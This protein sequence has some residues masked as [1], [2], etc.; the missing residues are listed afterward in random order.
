MVTRFRPRAGHSLVK[1]RSVKRAGLNGCFRPLAGHS[2]VNNG[3]HIHLRA[4]AVFVPLRG[5]A[6]SRTRWA[7]GTDRHRFRPLA[8]HSLV[9]AEYGDK[10]Q[11]S[12]RFRPLAGHSLVNAQGNADRL[13]QGFR[14]L[15][16]HSLVISP[17]PPGLSRCRFRPLAGHSLVR[18]NCTA[19]A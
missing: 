2:L 18:Q 4:P 10:E 17:A 16:G 13:Y 3:C 14:P 7:I 5:I 19:G 9:S 12:G 15:A 11:D 6:W 1:F 8:G